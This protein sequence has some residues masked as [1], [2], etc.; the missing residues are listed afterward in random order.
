[1][2]IKTKEN[3]QLKLI[4]DV[5]KEFRE[6][7]ELTFKLENIQVAKISAEIINTKVNNQ[8]N[9]I[10]VTINQI[11]PKFDEKSKNYDKIQKE[12]IEILNDYELVL[13]QFC[14]K[15]DIQIKKLILQK[16]EFESEI[17]KI[18]G[19]LKV[20]QE[21]LKKNNIVKEVVDKLKKKSV[22][23]ELLEDAE[24]EASNIE[25][26]KKIKN[27]RSKINACNKKI[28][29]LNEEKIKKVFEAMEVGD[30]QLVVEIKKPRKLKKVVKF[31]A[32]RFNT[33][34]IV[35]KNVL[36]PLKQ[37]V[38]KFRLTQLDLKNLE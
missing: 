38:D 13:K 11:N 26:E 8:L 1:M 2:R 28:N 3:E 34:K 32:N 33:Y 37:R 14:D 35:C 5:E 23:K 27:I 10:K 21:Q 36:D 20:Q 4:A 24:C 12:M 25:Y 6:Q 16:F 15:Y 17:L 30:R 22:K 7:L 9:S 31:F 29:L 18:I 19:N